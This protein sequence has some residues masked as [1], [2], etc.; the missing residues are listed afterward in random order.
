M[1]KSRR[2]EGSTQVLLVNIDCFQQTRP[3]RLKP[4]A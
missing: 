2:S 1:Q 3:F 4:G